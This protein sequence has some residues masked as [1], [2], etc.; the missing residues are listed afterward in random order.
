[1]NDNE[2][3]FKILVVDDDP[4]VLEDT[5][6][7]YQD[8]IYLGD[9][10]D[11]FGKGA[12]GSVSSA[13]NTIEAEKILRANFKKDSKL[14]QL[15][16]VDERMPEERG[17]EFVD[18]MRWV[19]SGRR[20]GALLVTG[21]STDVPVVNSRERGV[22]RYISKPVT[23]SIIKPHLDDLVKVIFSREKPRKKEL[24]QTFLFKRISGKEE[25]SDYFKLRY[26]VYDFMNY[27]SR[28]N[29]TS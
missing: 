14:V 7:M 16:H 24:D 10:D 18:R 9:F 25:L 27:I 26:S 8:M 23:P 28:P 5:V 2:I 13:K 20:I 1:M 19:Y 15:L 6:F 29:L 11:I 12:E 22:Y 21:Y 3:K 17:S 4:L